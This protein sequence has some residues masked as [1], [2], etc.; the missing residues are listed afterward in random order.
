LDVYNLLKEKGI[1]LPIP[2]ISIDNT[3]KE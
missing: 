1:H 3:N 2:K